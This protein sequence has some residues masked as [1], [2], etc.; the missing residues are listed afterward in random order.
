MSRDDGLAWIDAKDVQRLT[1]MPFLIET[2]RT[3][4]QREWVSP[5]RQFHQVDR[6]T[7][8]ML[9]AGWSSSGRIGV[10]VT[11]VHPERVPSIAAKYLLINA[12]SGELLALIDGAMLTSRRT[13]AA[14]ALAADY[15]ARHDS[16]T[17]LL[18]GTGALAPHMIEAHAGVRPI[19]TL[20]L[21]G[22]EH[23]KATM[24]LERVGM[25]VEEAYVVA[26]FD[27]ALRSSDIVSAA[28]A[29]VHPLVKG[30]LLAPGTHVD[31]VGAYREDMAEAD[32]ETFRRARVFVD[33]RAGALE[34]AGDLL[35]AIASGAF[36]ASEIEAELTD[37]C[38]G[39][40]EGRGSDRQSITVFKSVGLAVEDL[41]A[42]ELVFD[43]WRSERRAACSEEQLH[44]P[45]SFAPGPPA[46]HVLKSRPSIR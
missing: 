35:T 22:R 20:R 11:T 29:S 27:E 34:E 43:S 13:A 18:L 21:W 28:T 38:R 46:T 33:A 9:M 1:P 37:L 23:S 6:E 12:A 7:Q 17:L 26:D 3:A 41:A 30:A 15:L 24:L 40:H 42:A 5:P 14:S 16:K 39:R 36:S 32:S 44:N 10:K 2:L 8:L 31:L 19:R 25:L 45:N 4:M